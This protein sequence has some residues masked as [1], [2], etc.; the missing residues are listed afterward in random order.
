M[1]SDINTVVTNISEH[2]INFQIR[3]ISN[4][5]SNLLKAYSVLYMYMFNVESELLR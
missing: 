1:P 5:G 3:S 2:L 4:L